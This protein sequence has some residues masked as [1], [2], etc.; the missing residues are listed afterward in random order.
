M[1]K[2]ALILA[3]ALVFTGVQFL[4]AQK[5]ET[6]TFP[7]FTG[8]SLGAGVTVYLNQGN[9]QKVQLTGDAEVI[10]KLITE[11]KDG[12]LVIRYPHEKKFGYFSY[13]SA[14]RKHV[15]MHITMSQ[16]DGLK[17][18]G[19]GSIIAGDLIDTKE[20]DITISGT[21][22]VRMDNLKANKVSAHLSGTG[23]LSLAGQQTAS[24]FS[25][26]ISGTGSVKALDFKADVVNVTVSGT[27]S[28]SITANKNLTANISG[29]GSVSYRG[30]PQVKSRISGIGHVRAVK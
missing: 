3:V 24:E 1:K 2:R 22:N 17:V 23:A 9:P 30:N 11:V 20:L 16:I 13:N 26:S 5:S 7:V 8:I 6:R 19:T 12:K 10:G 25:S 18:S 21:G 27:G 4:Y 29:I 15:D 14:E 28:C